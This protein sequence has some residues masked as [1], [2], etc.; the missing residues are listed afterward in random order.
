MKKSS[1]RII[2]ALLVLGV[3]WLIVPG[4]RADENDDYLNAIAEHA[5]QLLADSQALTWPYG[6][7][8]GPSGYGAPAAP[9]VAPQVKFTPQPV[10]QAS[11][12]FA[13]MV[14]QNQERVR[15]Q[16]LQTRQQILQRSQEIMQQSQMQMMGL[17][18]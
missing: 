9:A 10:P 17:Q 1:L 18:R 15:Q 6:E 4:V 16:I 2:R 13:Q 5:R 14:R 11:D 12:A 3:L 8:D 7:S